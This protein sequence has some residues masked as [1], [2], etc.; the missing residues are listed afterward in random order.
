MRTMFWY[1]FAGLAAIS[2]SATGCSRG[3]TRAEALPA[4]HDSSAAVVRVKTGKPLRKT[5]VL[6]TTQP[7]RIEAF[8][9][10]LVFSKLAGYVAKV[11]VDIGDNVKR[12]QPLATLYVPELID[13]VQ[14]KTAIV[15]QAEAQSKQA[16]AAV[17][18]IKAA[19]DTADAKVAEAHAGVARA[20]SERERWKSEYGRMKQLATSGSVTQ[21]LADETLNQLRA[22]EAAL[23]AANATVKSA[24]ATAREARIN[25]KKTEADRSA[26]DARVVVKKADL[27]QAK[28]LLSYATLRSP[29]DGVVTKRS[30]NTGNFVQPATSTANPLLEVARTD[31]VRVFVEIPELEAALVD[32]ADPATVRIQAMPEK[33]IS[34]AV[35][36][37]SWSLYVANRSLRAEIDLPNTKSKLRPG[38]YANATILLDKRENALALPNTAIAW[39][40]TQAY[41]W[42]IDSGK[43]VRRDLVIGLRN[44]SET[45]VL[46]G[47]NENDVIVVQPGEALQAGAPVAAI[48]SPSD[49]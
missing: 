17:E 12:G 5:L 8:E 47:I 26:A 27:A 40:G 16:A 33:P 18:A 2:L 11:Q 43:A 31:K 49:R 36:R 42:S 13:A 10:T 30:V 22:A 20:L 41:C 29:F 24:E 23:T 28:T 15:N 45:E 7:A 37:T 38:M 4:Q 6:T 14:Q 39:D 25:V 21:K 9:D 34:A 35:T 19:V 46:K 32:V 3:A 1:L 48:D 44:S